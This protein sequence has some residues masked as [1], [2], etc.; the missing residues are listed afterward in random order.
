[1]FGASENAENVESAKTH[2]SVVASL[3]DLNFNFMATLFMLSFVWLAS[4]QEPRLVAES[5]LPEN[6]TGTFD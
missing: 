6:Q 5:L 2:P 3:V 1:M 4:L